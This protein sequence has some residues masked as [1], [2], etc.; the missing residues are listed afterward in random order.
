MTIKVGSVYN[1]TVKS[2]NTASAFSWPSK[3]PDSGNK[4]M[5]NKVIKITKKLNPKDSLDYDYVG[6]IYD[7]IDGAVELKNIKIV[8]EQLILKSSTLK[9]AGKGKKSKKITK[10]KSK[11]KSKKRTKK[12]SNKRSNKRFPRK[13]RRSYIK[14][15]KK[16]KKRKMSKNKNK[17]KGGSSSDAVPEWELATWD[18]PAL[19]KRAEEMGVTKG[20][21]VV[22]GESANP[23]WVAID[24]IMAAAEWPTEPPPSGQAD[25]DEDEDDITVLQN[26][27][28]L[29]KQQIQEADLNSQRFRQLGLEADAR[30]ADLDA[31]MALRA[32]KDAELKR[33]VTAFQH[34]GEH[35]S[36]DEHAVQQ[37]TT[38][39]PIRHQIQ[40][41]DE[42]QADLNARLALRAQK[43]AELMD[44]LGSKKGAGRSRKGETQRGAVGA[45]PLPKK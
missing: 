3:I 1:V 7:K 41:A 37:E 30:Q 31:Q 33:T 43:D 38:D 11:K 25:E 20:A 17:M 4:Y 13:T 24:L 35:D 10:K 18:L 42:R 28:D 39:D 19:Y 22:A 23:K 26:T 36:T 27:A 9:V 21:L 6:D 14:K 5:K 12:R 44:T 16:T 40:E 29:I 15:T 32:Q 2:G 8:S 34:V 45:R